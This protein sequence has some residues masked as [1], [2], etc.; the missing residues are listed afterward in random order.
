MEEKFKENELQEQ[1]NGQEKKKG[2][3]DRKRKRLG[4][5]D[6]TRNGTMLI[7]F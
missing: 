7:I 2:S 3:R 4:N 5:L 6:M 1:K